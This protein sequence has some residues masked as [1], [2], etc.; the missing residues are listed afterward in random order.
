MNAGRETGAGSQANGAAPADHPDTIF[1]NGKFITADESFRIANAVA[2]RDGRF[3][4]VG[5]EADIAALAG[6]STTVVDL[7]GRTVLPGLIDT[8]V[9]VERAGLLKYTVQLNDVS[10]VEQALAR[11]S[12]YAAKLPKGQWL[13]GGQWHPLAQLAEKRLLTREELDRVAPDNPVCL[14]IGHF[15]MA[16]SAAL[17]LAGISKDTPAS[18]WW[19]H[20]SRPGDR[21]AQR[22]ARGSG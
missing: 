6:P 12:S 21:R 3:L 22:Y 15:T 17:A 9:H 16:N 5:D 4:A 11:I 13:R 10:T 19:H 1:I 20:S 18:R 2:V 14:P 7:Q 8:H